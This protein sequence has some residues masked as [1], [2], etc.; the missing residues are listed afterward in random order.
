[1]KKADAKGDAV[2]GGAAPESVYVESE[3]VVINTPKIIVPGG[4]M[5]DKL[6]PFL[7]MIVVVG[8]FIL[9]NLY[10]KVT[11]YEKGGVAGANTGSTA[12]GNT[13]PVADPNQ[14]A[15]PP[16]VTELTGDQWDEM[17]AKAE[18]SKGADG[19][20]VTVVEFTDYQCPFCGRYYTD[21]YSQLMKDY[22]DTGKVRY[23]T[24]DLPLSFHP[25]AKPGALAARCAGDQDKYWEM[26]DILF[27]KQ[28]EWSEGSD[29]KDKLVG[30]AGD[31]GLNV[32][33]FTSCYDDGTHNAAIDAAVAYAQSV[34]ANGTPTFY[35]EGKQLVGA[36]PY[37]AFQTALDE[38]LGS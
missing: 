4:V 18:Y 8:A 34:G 28:A 38:A 2:K 17:L 21:T 22:V 5:K 13:A 26:H 14:P 16:P 24:M 10:G 11:V 9:G 36:Q 19:A 30:Y 23:I 31:I 7:V 20:A 3:H 33:T 12:T 32:S 27:E 6:V 25:N 35:I 29:A 37:S 15:A 1:M